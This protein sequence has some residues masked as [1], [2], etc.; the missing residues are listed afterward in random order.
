MIGC[1]LVQ[2]LEPLTG[3]TL[4][5]TAG[6]TEECVTSTITDGQLIYTTGG[7]PKNHVAAI[8]ADG[9]AQ[10]VWESPSRVYVPSMVIKAGYLY[11]VLD[12][13]V[14]ICWKADTGAEQWKERIGGT[15]SGSVVLQGDKLF[16][17]DE[18]GRTLIWKA[19][20]E[21][22]EQLGENRLGTEAFATPTICGCRIYARVAEQ[23]D[24]KRQEWLYS[25]GK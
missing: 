10:V 23:V 21:K 9:S 17:T 18:S 22:F 15:F 7:Y 4:W 16:A 6:S 1:N 2:G 11:A 3:K 14:A 13:G 5:E 8:K 25:L 12:A 20:P 19:T 24:G